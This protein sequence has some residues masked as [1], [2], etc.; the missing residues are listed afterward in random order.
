MPLPCPSSDL[1]RFEANDFSY[2]IIK[3]YQLDLVKEAASGANHEAKVDSQLAVVRDLRASPVALAPRLLLLRLAC[4]HSA[5][6]DALAPRLLRSCL[7]CCP[8]LTSPSPPP[9]DL[10]KFMEFALQRKRF[11]TR[12]FTLLEKALQ[13]EAKP[14]QYFAPPNHEHL[15]TSV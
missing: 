7:S 4:C 11:N 9:Q 8:R 1:C 13:D 2:H 5:S 15:E 12:I 14:F 6:P 10:D 3:A